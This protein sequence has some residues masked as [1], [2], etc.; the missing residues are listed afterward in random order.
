MRQENCCN[1]GE[2]FDL[3]PRHK[4]QSYCMK[5]ECRR[6]RRAAWQRQKMHIDP[7]YRANQ[8]VSNKNW[9]QNNPDYWKEY[10]SRNPDKT[11]RN[12]ILQGVRNRKRKGTSVN[13]KMDA[14]SIAKMDALNPSEVEV[15][16]RF[17]LVPVIAKMDASMVN[18]LRISSP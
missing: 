3:S 2:L 14:S 10:R 9:A 12:R 15:V 18:I 5:P 16:G 7:D 6:A 17:W 1:C 11:Q 8:K 4:N 13:A